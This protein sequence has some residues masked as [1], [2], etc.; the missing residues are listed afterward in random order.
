MNNQDTFDKVVK[1]LLKQGEKA[2]EADTRVCLLR[3]VNG[4]KCAVGLLIEDSAYHPSW[5]KISIWEGDL[6]EYLEEQ[7]FDVSFLGKLQVI[8]DQ[9]EV[10][11][12]EDR[13]KELA[14]ANNLTYRGEAA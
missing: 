6:H 10:G 9:S 3:G 8:H 12:W 4:T 7:G 2:L 13:L 14:K 1:G 11:D 5:E